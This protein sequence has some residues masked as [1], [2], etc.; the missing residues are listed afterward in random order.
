MRKDRILAL[1]A[2]LDQTPEDKFDMRFFF[3]QKDG[4][5]LQSGSWNEFQGFGMNDNLLGWTKCG[6]AA[7]VAGWAVALATLQMEANPSDSQFD[8]LK[9]NNLFP[10]K[11]YSSEE[12]YVKIWREGCGFNVATAATHYLEIDASVAQG[13]FYAGPSSFWD[14]YGDELGIKRID[15]SDDEGLPSFYID[16]A[17]IKPKHAA[18]VLRMI[19]NGT[20]EDGYRNA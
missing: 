19:A 7:C 4:D 12:D 5:G 18:K 16:W 20:I 2:L 11:C 9:Q 15:K 6:T 8:E 3:S 10:L 14:V 17:S 1:A 13:L